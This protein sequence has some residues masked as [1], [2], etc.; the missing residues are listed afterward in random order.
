MD[1]EDLV[2]V[3]TSLESTAATLEKTEILADVFAST[4]PEHLEMVVTLIR[5][6]VFADWESEDLGVSS[7]LALEAI[8]KA[9]GIPTS[10]IEDWWREEGDLG[11]AAATAVENKEQATLF[12]EPL[13]VRNVHA[14][15]RELADYEG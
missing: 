3:Y 12:S 7:S 15:L 6:S 9:T 2:A 8:E 11:S 4:D 14:R 1:Y 5:G 13:T 10:R